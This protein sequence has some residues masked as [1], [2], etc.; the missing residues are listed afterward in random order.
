MD[1]SFGY[2]SSG[3]LFSGIIP[4]NN[5]VSRQKE[6]FQRLAKYIGCNFI[7]CNLYTIYY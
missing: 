3:V 6:V 5:N 4:S 7:H 1:V 2:I